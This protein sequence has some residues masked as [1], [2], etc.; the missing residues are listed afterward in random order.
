M[1]GRLLCVDG[2][3]HRP[4]ELARLLPLDILAQGVGDR[5]PEEVLRA[6]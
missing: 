4:E 3:T 6:F 5:T 2:P 1:R